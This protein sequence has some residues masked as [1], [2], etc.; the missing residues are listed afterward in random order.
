MLYDRPCEHAFGLT[1]T[2][3]ESDTFRVCYC[4]SGYIDHRMFKLARSQIYDIRSGDVEAKLVDLG[5]AE[6]LVPTDP[7]LQKVQKLVRLGYPKTN[8]LQA[9]A[10]IAE[11]PWSISRYEQMHGVGSAQKNYTSST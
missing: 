6:T 1:S 2:K 4:A 7:T 8:L 5:R 11:A 9:F 10:L 3:L